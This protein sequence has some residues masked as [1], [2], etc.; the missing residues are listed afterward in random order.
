MKKTY[1]FV[2]SGLSHDCVKVAEQ[3]L[4][5]VNTGAI[6]GFALV[7]MCKERQY[8]TAIAGEAYR[9]PTFTR[10]MV[11]ALDDEL[12]ELVDS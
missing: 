6:I 10:G 5:D 3:F 1:S 2:K 9:S 8:I 12:R 4:K 11:L 7:A